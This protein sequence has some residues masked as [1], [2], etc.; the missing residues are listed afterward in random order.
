MDPQGFWSLPLFPYRPIINEEAL[1]GELQGGAVSFTAKYPGSCGSCGAK[2][3]AGVE[4]CYI[5]EVLV[6]VDEH[7]CEAKPPHEWESFG[8]KPENVCARCFTVHN[9]E[10]L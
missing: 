6:L 4:V 9:G 2:F 7:D 10:C 1:G 3:P 8:M 5:D